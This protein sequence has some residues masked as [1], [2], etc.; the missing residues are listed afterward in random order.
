MRI[1]ECKTSEKEFWELKCGDVFK[2]KLPFDEDEKILMKCREESTINAV[3]LE[4]GIL[5]TL[6]LSLEC[7]LVDAALTIKPNLNLP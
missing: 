4:T 7:T 6:G 1:V 5:Y 2:V 3:D